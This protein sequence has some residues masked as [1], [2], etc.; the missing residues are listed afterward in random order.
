LAAIAVGSGAANADEVAGNIYTLSGDQIMKCDIS[1][2]SQRSNSM[3]I[4][5]P[6][7]CANVISKIYR[8]NDVSQSHWA[9]WFIDAVSYA[10]ITGGCGGGKFCPDALVTR[11][12]LAVMLTRALD[13]K[14]RGPVSYRA[15]AEALGENK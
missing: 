10:G 4:V 15:V 2:F 12:E 1:T 13:L 5:I 8:Y 7:S 3:T 9:F 11:A 14:L 6:D